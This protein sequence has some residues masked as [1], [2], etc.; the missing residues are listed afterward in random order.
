MVNG[1]I[2][3]DG[4]EHVGKSTLACY[5]SEHYNAVVF[6]RGYRFKDKI[7]TYH[8]SALRKAVALSATRLVVIDRL[9]M[10]ENVYGQVYRGGTRWPH[11]GRMFDR[12]LRRF[13]ALQVVAVPEDPGHAIKILR[14]KPG[15]DLYQDERQAVEASNCYLRL[16]QAVH[17]VPL[18]D[19]V[20][21]AGTGYLFE[22]ADRE[23]LFRDDVV[24]YDYTRWS[25]RDMAQ[26]LVARLNT[27]RSRAG[28][29]ELDPTF[30]NLAGRLT[31]ATTLLVG[32]RCNVK[33]QKIRWPFFDY[34]NCSLFLAEAHS[35]AGIEEENLAWTNA[36]DPG[37]E[38][39]L[40]A[41]ETQPFRYV[42]LGK[43]AFSA[44][45]DAGVCDRHNVCFVPHPQ[46]VRRFNHDSQPDYGKLIF[47]SIPK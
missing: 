9:W 34:S 40:E 25:T 15:R 19:R 43:M 46:A 3:L 26:Y 31:G 22:L 6:H 7:F 11:Q 21:A 42:A 17:D 4:P 33:S 12:I 14:A 45:V 35:L 41:T 47:N 29:L 10:S 30:N 20:P 16:A 1:I 13:H 39:V 2:C 37:F 38:Q 28:S 24:W 32:D 44:L 5:L 23:R 36:N 18:A 8:T 27:L